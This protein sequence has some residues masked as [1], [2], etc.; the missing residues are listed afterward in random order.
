MRESTVKE[1]MTQFIQTIPIGSTVIESAQIM[2]EVGIGSIV[3]VSHEGKPVGIV[4]ER[5]I[6]AKV[7][8][9]DLNSSKVPV[10]KIM[11]QPIITI[12]P[13]KI[14]DEAA[15]MMSIYGI[16]RLVVI[17]KD[18][19]PSGIVT[20]TDIA[21]WLSRSEDYKNNALNAIARLHNMEQS[22]PYQ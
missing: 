4:T 10:E 6:V 13:D 22:I 19:K 17:G 9:Q 11:S 8:L 16:R 5:D 3:V 2:S 12:E 15:L 20:T 18:G 21:W 14:I 1:I 7:A